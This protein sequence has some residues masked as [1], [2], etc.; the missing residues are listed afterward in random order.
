[1]P[2]MI[3]HHL[4]HDF[5]KQPH[6]LDR[7]IMLPIRAAQ[8]LRGRRVRFLLHQHGEE[9]PLLD[10][11][12]GSQVRAAHG[13]RGVYLRGRGPGFEAGGS[14][15]VAAAERDWFF[16]AGIVGKG[17][18]ADGTVLVFFWEVSWLEFGKGS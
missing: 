17:V 2:T 5:E 6:E 8:S 13:A 7:G 3:R 4:Q 15:D 14:E 9:F 18:H 1:M 12:T 10:A 16:G 11:R